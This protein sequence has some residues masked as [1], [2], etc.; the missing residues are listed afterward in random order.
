M[1]IPSFK[2]SKLVIITNCVWNCIYYR[3]CLHYIMCIQRSGSIYLVPHLFIEVVLLLVAT[4]LEC[5]LA[6]QPQLLD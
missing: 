2:G 5:Q 3:S 6:V 4:L 1:T